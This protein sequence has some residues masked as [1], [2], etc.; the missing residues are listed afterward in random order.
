M[1]VFIW[2]WNCDFNEREMI[3]TLDKSFVGND[4]PVNTS[5]FNMSIFLIEERRN[6]YWLWIKDWL[7]QDIE[8]VRIMRRKLYMQMWREG[9]RKRKREDDEWKK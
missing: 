3:S 4:C 7:W 8:K 1:K 5:R 6:L 2:K 9:E